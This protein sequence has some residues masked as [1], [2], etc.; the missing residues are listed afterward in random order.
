MFGANQH[1]DVGVHGTHCNANAYGV[2]L[3][4]DN[5]LHPLLT[6]YGKHMI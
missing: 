3:E 1:V 2:G 5:H 6:P 4:E